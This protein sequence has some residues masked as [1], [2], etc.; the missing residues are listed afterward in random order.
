MLPNLK[1]F[2]CARAWRLCDIH[3]DRCREYYYAAE[4]DCREY[5][6]TPV[7]SGKFLD[8]VLHAVFIFPIDTVN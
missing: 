5:I 8:D 4:T 1:G 7:Q 3:F 2:G 6:V